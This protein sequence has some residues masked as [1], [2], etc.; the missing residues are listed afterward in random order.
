MCLICTHLTARFKD[1]KST[2]GTATC[3]VTSVKCVEGDDWSKDMR[4][5]TLRI[6]SRKA[7]QIG[8]SLKCRV[9]GEGTAEITLSPSQT[10]KF[11]KGD[12]NA[13]DAC[14]PVDIHFVPQAHGALSCCIGFNMFR[15]FTPCFIYVFLI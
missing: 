9:C 13:C 10:A 1:T 11:L 2:C 6:L 12:P 14:Y 5:E 15:L 8:L 3:T 7:A 4:S